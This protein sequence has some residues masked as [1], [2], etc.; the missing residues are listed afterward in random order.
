MST[1]KR[2]ESLARVCCKTNTVHRDRAEC[3]VVFIRTLGAHHHLGRV[4]ARLNK[5]LNLIIKITSQVKFEN[6][7]PTH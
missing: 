1:V 3:S 7:N 5:K 6:Y 4:I 2:K